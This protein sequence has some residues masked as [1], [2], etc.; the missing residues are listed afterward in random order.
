MSASVQSA[1]FWH[2]QLCS[3]L[4]KT[5]RQSLDPWEH[6]I[7]VCCFIL[8]YLGARGD[9]VATELVSYPDMYWCLQHRLSMICTFLSF[10]LEFPT[11]WPQIYVWLQDGTWMLETMRSSEELLG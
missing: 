7:P 3:S 10:I 1:V 4:L 2:Q 11:S 5:G 9:I 6:F 8:R